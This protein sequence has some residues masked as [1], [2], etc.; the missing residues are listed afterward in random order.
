[1]ADVLELSDGSIHT[2]FDIRDVM[3]L[4]DTHVGSEVRRWLEEYLTE[5]DDLGDYVSDLEAEVKGIRD[6]HHEV[7]NSLREESEK[8]ACLIRE[9]DIDRKALSTAAGRI[10]TITWRELERAECMKRTTRR[11]RTPSSCRR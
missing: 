2:V 11:W 5:D 9:R 4:I 6:H 3:E 10:G 8:I 7:K 1:M